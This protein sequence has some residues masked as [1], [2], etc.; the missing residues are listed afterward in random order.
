MKRAS[1]LEELKCR[2]FLS[3]WLDLLRDPMY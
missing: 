1:P 2:R 3:S